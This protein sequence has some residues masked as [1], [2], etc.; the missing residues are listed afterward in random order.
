MARQIQVLILGF[1]LMLAGGG[2]AKYVDTSGGRV[3]V[4]SVNY[5]GQGGLRYHARLYRPHSAGE[6]ERVPA[7]LA[8]HGY[9]NSNEMQ[10]PFAIELS[11]RGFVVLAPDMPGHGYTQP[12]AFANALGGPDSLA[13]LR[14]L[15]GVDP[16]RI[17]LLGHSMGG[18]SSLF[19]TAAHPDGYQAIVIEGSSTGTLGAPEGTPTAPRNIA[20]VYSRFD[21]FSG[22]MWETPDASDV[23]ASSKMKALF[24]TGDGNVEPGRIYGSVEQGSARVLHQ[25]GTTHAGNHFSNAAIAPA[26]DWLSLTLGVEPALPSTNQIWI[27]REVGTLITL[28]GL[29]V[30]IIG[31]A[32]T[33]LALPV[34]ATLRGSPSQPNGLT[35]AGWWIG[36]AVFGLLPILLYFPLTLIGDLQAW[37]P[38]WLL[39]QSVTNQLVFWAL[40]T[41]LVSLGLFLTWHAVTHRRRRALFRDYNLIMSKGQSAGDLA[42]LV[43]LIAGVIVTSCIALALIGA[44]FGSDARFWV[45]AVKTP[46]PLQA[47]L[48][49]TYGLAFTAFFLVTGLALQG[50]LRRR[51]LTPVHEFLINWTLLVGPWLFL[52]AGQYGALF[53]SGTLALPFVPLFS[54]IAFQFVPLMTIAALIYTCLYRATGT[55]L[56]GALL[57]GALTG[58]I[59]AASQATHFAY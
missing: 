8:T 54:I 39:G 33:L 30:L 14:Q 24:G 13:Y 34:F 5:I 43:L 28:I 47:R 35:G 1:I 38:S 17:G 16:D 10:A 4:S 2:L 18:W 6:T 59:V 36:A 22:F 25:P 7:I 49:V 31:L 52:L 42:R 26:I 41:G 12:P 56:P 50:Q 58:W 40:T 19:A 27:W 11:R 46:S 57:N 53:T 45:F 21:E 32:G 51:D 3:D 29:V 48:A 20:V 23:P 55:I 37:T 44:L 9:I 15:S